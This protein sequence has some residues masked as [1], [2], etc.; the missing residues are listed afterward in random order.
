MEIEIVREQPVE[1]IRVLQSNCV[2]RLTDSE[3]RVEHKECLR[4]AW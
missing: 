1:V 2:G 3:Q 4:T